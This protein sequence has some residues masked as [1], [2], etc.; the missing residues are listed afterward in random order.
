MAVPSEPL[1]SVFIG[2]E[3]ELGSIRSLLHRAAGGEAQAL[4]V[5]G[6]AG[7]GK[8]ALVARACATLPDAFTLVGTCLPLTSMSIPLL[9]IRSALRGFGRPEPAPPDSVDTGEERD[10]AVHF[11]AWLDELCELQH[12]TFVIDDL[13][14]ADRS[15][16]DTL[17]Y[18]L[19]GPVR[20]RLALVAT[21]RREEV[22][23]GHPLQRWLA[24]VRRLP[25]VT[26]LDLDPLG[27]PETGQQ[28]SALLGASA[29][30]SLIEDV[31]RRTR[32]NPYFNRLIVAGLFPNARNVSETFPSDLRSAVLQSWYRLPAPTRE[33]ATVLAVGGA[34]MHADEL[35]RVVGTTEVDEVRDRLHAAVDAGTLDLQADGA[36]WFH[37]PMN[38][39]V[40]EAVLAQDERRV[41]HV[42]FAELLEARFTSG[43]TDLETVVAIADHRYRAG[44]ARAGYD[45]ALVASEAIGVS[46]GAAERLRLLRRAVTLRPELTDVAVSLDDLLRRLRSAAAEV[47]AH[48][49]E[50]DAVEQLLDRTDRA[51]SPLV[52]SELLVRRMHLRFSM[53]LSFIDQAEMREAVRL[54]QVAPSSSEYAL[55]LAELAHAEL[56]HDSP[57]AHEHARRALEVARASGDTRAL[58]YALGANAMGAAQAGDGARAAAFAREGIDCAMRVRDWWA[59]THAVLW[60]GNALDMRGAEGFAEL[61]RR[62][63]EQMETHGAPHAYLAW[64]SASEAAG[65]MDVGS[66]R[67]CE[68]CLRLVLGSDPGPLADVSAR[69]TAARLA[70]WQG[71]QSEAENHLQR[72]DELIVAGSQFLAFEFATVRAEVRLGAGDPAGAFRAALAGASTEGIA[73]TMCE[74]LMPLAARALADQVQAAR[75]EGRAAAEVHD[76]L[77]ALVARF[78]HVIR[79]IGPSTE[80]WEHQIVALDAM[81]VA[82]RFRARSD[83][84]QAEAWVTAVTECARGNLLWEEAYSTWRAAEALLGGL[85]DRSRGAAMLRDGLALAGR[86]C[87]RPV[88]EELRELATRARIATAEPVA[89]SSVEPAALHGFTAREREILDLVAVGR[90]YSEIARALTISEKTVSSHV[91][92]LLAKTGTANR[93]ELAG[94]VHRIARNR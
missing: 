67:E 80:L 35:A 15:T 51:T 68:E 28:I 46:G 70:T 71:R 24:D 34:A 47:G 12:V 48:A 20:R 16:L 10:Y 88:E 81:Y 26:E 56:W 58:A 52:A 61:L 93:V 91:S 17:M 85:R 23:A 89:A 40:L 32:G 22:G 55:A 21:I 82:E 3:R 27:R 77:D 90:T 37:H 83:P 14:W 49:D 72:A 57:D 63:R 50:L 36:F 9:P 92:H 94:L 44:D 11:D 78:P 25:R 73:P 60:E 7:V 62:R 76:E 84:R 86:L 5:S 66:W 30:Q 29:H 75:D 53:G 69:L 8:T 45:W 64:V 54:S 4:V 42:R 41:W 6:D 1:D 33:L 39:E 79:D 74:W 59:C 38:V 13:Q 43:S 18:V 87:A 65:R 19:A 31:H 2:R